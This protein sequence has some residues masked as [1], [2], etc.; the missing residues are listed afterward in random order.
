MRALIFGVTG[1]D[2]SFLAR[3]LLDKG[4][5][6]FGTRSRPEERIPTDSQIL[7]KDIKLFYCDLLESDSVKKIIENVKPAE[8]YNLAAQSNVGFSFL[9]PLSVD[10]NSSGALNVLRSVIL[11]GLGDYTKVFQASS[12]EIF[13]KKHG[14]VNENSGFL[15][16]SPYGVSKL[17][18]FWMTV[19]FREQ[20]GVHASNGILFNHESERRTGE[21]VSRK[22]TSAAARIKY[23]KQDCLELGNLN[24]SKDWGYAPDFTEFMWLTLQN[25]ADDYICSTGEARTVR[26]FCQI[27]FDRVGIPLRFE[28]DGLDEMGMDENG[29]VIVK[30]NPRFY[31]P[32]DPPMV[33]DNTK[34]RGLGWKPTHSFE[35]WVGKMINYDLK[36][37]K[38]L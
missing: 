19:L 18:S 16:T 4:Y 30:V 9:K 8:I 34:A 2:G 35:E 10:V 14:I 38:F 25:K 1:Q 6:V 12:S 21:F 32:C 20:Y 15:P 17:F 27:V 22:I 29:R 37:Q 31:R 23:G 13:G 5:E 26:E 33:G 28:G 36:I 3:Q 11:T 7:P 24:S